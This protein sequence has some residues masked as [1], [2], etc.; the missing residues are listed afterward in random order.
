MNLITYTSFDLG[1]KIESKVIEELNVREEVRVIV[2]LKD[3]VE[4]QG[5]K[6]SKRFGLLKEK[7][8]GVQE[9]LLYSLPKNELKLIR[10][11][12][13]INAIAGYLTKN[14]LA[15]FQAS[16][17]IERVYEDRIAYVSL[18]E[19]VPLIKADLVQSSGITGLGQSV[20]VIDTGVD[21]RHVDL[22]NASCA[23]TGSIISGVEAPNLVESSHPYSN[24]DNNTW[25]ITRPGYENI[26]V[27]FTDINVEANYDFVYILDANNNIVQMF[28]GGYSNIWS[29]SIPGD[30]IKVNLVANYSITDW[31][32]KIDKDLN[33]TISSTWSNCG[34]VVNGFDFVNN[35]YNPMDDEGHGTHVSGIIASQNSTYKGVASGAK[36]VAAKVLDAQGK[37]FFSNVTSAIDWCIE[38]KSDFNIMAINMS[39]GD[40]GQYN[41]PSIQCDPY[42][43]AQAISAAV[44][45]GIF[46]AVAS[47]NEAYT[48][49]ISYPACA[50][51]ATSVGAV[52]DADVG[53]KNWAPTCTDNSTYA[54]KIV[55]F[56]NRDEILDLLAPGCSITSLKLGGG[57]VA[58]CG[59]SMAAPHVAGVAA[60]MKQNNPS[61]TPGQIRDIMKSTGKSINDSSTGLT[62]PRVDA[63]AAV[64]YP[65]EFVSITLIG[66][67]VDFGSLNPGT[68]DNN[69]LGNSSNQYLVQ[70]D[71][72]TNVNVDLYQKGTDFNYGVETITVNNMSWNSTNN[73]LTATNMTTSYNLIQSNIAPDTNVNL[74]YWLDIPVG[75]IAGAY[76]STISIKAVKT[77]SSP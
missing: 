42:A 6:N 66:F 4:I 62:F 74:Y 32:F 46:V 29:I 23:I 33:G 16:P 70:I 15:K 12:K 17:F 24:Y 60:L 36:I 57:T 2:I 40:G 20:C 30:T 8:K 45:Q 28:T 51:D 61:L 67:P 5:L 49:G 41:N 18:S 38:H 11:Y 56:T 22:G 27:H 68:N 64:N 75:K 47:G 25:T 72:T 63:N 31:G 76:S 26:A 43:T 37:G 44:A 53:R 35:D 77:G 52:Y 14:G 21:Y 3:T 71:A 50:S 10:K 1:A 69:A 7:I 13:N 9:Q 73:P 48:N 55:C 59:T 65:M 39:L 54:D 19:S 34:Q 58:Y